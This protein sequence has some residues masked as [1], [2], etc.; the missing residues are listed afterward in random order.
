MTSGS[1]DRGSGSRACCTSTSEATGESDFRGAIN[2]ADP[3]RPW[4][5]DFVGS[6]YTAVFW[7]SALAAWAGSD[8]FLS[9]IVGLPQ[10]IAVGGGFLISVVFGFTMAS[11]FLT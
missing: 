5:S 3:D 7:L 10:W 11:V 6:F 8:L 1:R 2:M 4:Q 9:R